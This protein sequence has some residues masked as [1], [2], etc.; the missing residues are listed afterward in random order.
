MNI[1]DVF[2]V[3]N[4]EWYKQSTIGT[5]PP[6][7][8]NPC[9]TVAMAPDGSS[10]NVYL[11]GGQNL[12]PFG[13][14]IQYDDMYILT[15]PSFTWVKVDMTGQSSP[16]ARAGHTCTMW[17]G[18]MVVIGGY[19]GKDISCD[20]P[21]IYVFNASSLKW[22]NDFTS[23]TSGSNSKDDY[24]SSI[25]QGSFGYQVP[26]PVQSVIGGGSQGGATATQPAAGSA[27]AG[28]IATG[29]PPTFTVTQSGSTVV[30]TSAP[31]GG[32]AQSNI[33]SKSGPNVGAITAGVLAAALAILA[34]YL[35]FCT[36]LYR[37]QLNLYKDHVAMAQR[38]DPSPVPWGP[39]GGR[40]SEKV[41]GAGVM[42]GPFG[43]EISNSSSGR[44]SV[45][46]SSHSGHPANSTLTPSFTPSFS[47]TPGGSGS[48]VPTA[49]TYA[50]GYGGGIMPGGERAGKGY[51]YGFG[52]QGRLSEEY[53]GTE[54]HGRM[55][56]P[57]GRPSGSTANSSTEDLLSGQ[58]PSFF[59]VV[60]N[61]RR[62]LRVVNSD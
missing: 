5:P 3:A 1:I 24:S 58:E 20:S 41:A 39:G 34:A 26:A 54:Y 47:A 7:R 22:S 62:T 45:G 40:T 60:L 11:Y 38:R 35:A 52:P 42:L 28:P 6:I 61:P 14:Q 32:S 53:E 27:T 55:S 10:F 25:L 18:Q 59:N 33:P 36:W 50:G 49:S 44:P 31:T 43:T 19:V 37:K 16:P 56:M 51:G 12:Q 23:V 57:Y 4:S 30:Q 48:S 9:A 46:E 29:K 13:D 21:G 8:V 17:D 2:D 15:I